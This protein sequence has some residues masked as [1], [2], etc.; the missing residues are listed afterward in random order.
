MRV[1]QRRHVRRP[2][3]ERLEP[4]IALTAG[5]GAASA[6]GRYIV[7][8]DD[9][10]AHPGEVARQVAGRYGGRPGH[11]YEHALKGFSTTL[12]SAA[13]EAMKGHPLVKSVEL[14]L[15]FRVTA[16]TLPTGVNRIDADLS[17][18]AKINGQDE[19]I[20]VDIAILDTGIDGSHPDLN[21]Y[22]AGSRNFVTGLAD[23]AWQDGHGHGTHVA[24]IAAALDNGVGVV[25]VAP[26]ARLWA[27]KV[28]ADNG[29]GSISDAL[30]AVDYLTAN[31]D[32]IEV[33]NMSFIEAGQSPAFHQAVRNA[34]AAGVVIVAGAGNDSQDIYGADKIY[35]TSDDYFPAS[36]PEV[37]TVSAMTDYDGR[38]GGSSGSYLAPFYGSDDA[39]A[40]YSNF[41]T[42]VA[43]WDGDPSTPNP[44]TSPGAGID[45]IM[46]GTQINSTN[47][48]GGYVVKDGTSM[49]SPHA[50]GLA[51]LFIAEYSR[52]AP[53]DINGD[54][55][56]N[57]ADV[58]ALRQSL[59]DRGKDQGDTTYGLRNGGDPDGNRERIGWAG[60]VN[61]S[62]PDTTAPAA[63]SGLVATA[64]IQRVTL[65]WGD[66]AE[67]D[68]AGYNLYRRSGSGNPFAKI[69][70]VTASEYT[71]T[72][73]TGGTTYEYYVTAFDQ[74]ANESAQS[75]AVSATAM[76]AATT[77]HV[78][79]LDGATVKSGTS[80][81]ARVTITVLDANG[82]PVSNATVVGNWSSG[83]SGTSTVTTN[84]QGLAVVE[85]KL[86]KGSV[87]RVTFT[88]SKLTHGSLTYDGAANIDPDGDS[89]GTS[90]TIYKVAP[91]AAAPL[92]AQSIDPV[93]G[94]P[95]RLAGAF[96]PTP[97]FTSVPPCL[98]GQ[99][100]DMI[101]PLE[102]TPF[103]NKKKF[104][105]L[106]LV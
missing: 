6:S 32:Q 88:V 14:D 51:A 26:G 106:S 104:S 66:N 7:V 91:T 76:A 5:L 64:G 60:P 81:K 102:E 99:I 11:V 23:T 46:P 80:W 71:D 9:S 83:S 33:A 105:L 67:S 20:D 18:V 22:S 95:S 25:G 65:N 3:V 75:A 10:V 101:L 39:F 84:A 36:Y 89:N 47:T 57:A 78:G 50:A 19:R 2:M 44:V 41:S 59:I 15:T 49:A 17:P 24:G 100:V 21:V 92:I 52:G 94:E 27:L 74:S 4:R 90:I 55:V 28:I 30:A 82:S 79:D 87:S 63:P 1:R 43:D 97:S 68:L 85:S 70:T 45:L 54:G 38:P 77:M 58:Y 69:A 103:W 12:P 96:Q 48:G 61:S 72:G 62:P 8:L 93:M 53:G 98:E 73:L 56:R 34:V 40:K 86:M 35:G 16:Q 42:S 29:T 31:A 13:A 37:L